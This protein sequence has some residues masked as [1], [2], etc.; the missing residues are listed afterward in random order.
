MI[1][2]GLIRF[3]RGAGQAGVREEIGP[4]RKLMVDANQVWDVDQAIEAMKALAEFDLWWIEEPT[5]PDDILGHAR[6]AQAVR[7]IGVATGEP[8]CRAA[9]IEDFGHQLESYTGIFHP[10]CWRLETWI[11]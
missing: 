1:R 5:S 8:F 6:I 2:P 4:D 9:C 3:I 11:L 7:P 10:T